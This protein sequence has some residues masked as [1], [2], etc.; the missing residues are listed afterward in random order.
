MW[1]LSFVISFADS[2]LRNEDEVSPRA[3]TLFDRRVAI[4]RWS[5]GD[6]ANNRLGGDDD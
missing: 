2:C 4:A 1:D 6:S 3:D 5:L